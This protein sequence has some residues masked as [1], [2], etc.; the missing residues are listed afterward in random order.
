MG[1]GRAKWVN[2]HGCIKA[3]AYQRIVSAFFDFLAKL[4]LPSLRFSSLE[5]QSGISGIV[6]SMSGEAK[7]YA[8]LA[9]QSK[10]LSAE[11]LV[12]KALF[13]DFGLNDIGNVLF[14]F[15]ATIDPKVVSYK[16]VIDTLNPPVSSVA[17]PITSEPLSS[18]TSTKDILPNTEAPQ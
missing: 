12:K 15:K 14:K 3:I 2:L 16:S 4:T 17:E 10:I 18:G 5:Y 1:F 8:A 11:P 7:S 6:V 13:S 9:L